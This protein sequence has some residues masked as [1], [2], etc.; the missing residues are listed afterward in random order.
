VTS[1]PTEPVVDGLRE[2]EM[3]MPV[4]RGDQIGVTAQDVVLLVQN[5]TGT[6]MLR[7]KPPAA[8][9]TSPP[10]TNT[11]SDTVLGINADVERDVD[12]DGLG[13][14][15][16]DSDDDGDGVLDASDNC[17]VT[18]GASQADGDGDGAGDICD[19]DDDNDGLPDLTEGALAAAPSPAG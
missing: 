6:S 18:A 12:G 7:W 14:E 1:G 15:T 5:V 10:P 4:R 19:E 13:D 16:Q 2:F 3:H 9:G 17:P 8:D 11:L